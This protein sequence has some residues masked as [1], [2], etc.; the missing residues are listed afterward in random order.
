MC[1]V[2]MRRADQH[3]ALGNLISMMIVPLDIGI[4][5]PLERLRSVRDAIERLK[6]ADQAGGL[7][8]IAS[9]IKALPAPVF[10]APWRF[11]PRKYWPHNITSTNVAGP[12]TPLYLGPHE[13]LHWYP[14]GV[15]W[16]DNALFLCTLSYREYLILGLVADPTIVT[17][18]WEANDDLL[19]SYEEIAAAAPPP[20]DELGQ[21]ATREE[22]PQ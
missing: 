13:L 10:A 5:D 22:L 14:F 15:Q 9:L 6:S 11:G 7:Y 16:N 18:I 4:T 20:D 17:D 21:P 1:P 19:A 12:R 8:D 3:G 2:S